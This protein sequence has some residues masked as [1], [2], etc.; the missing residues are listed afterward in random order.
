MIC[1]LKESWLVQIVSV[2]PS[3]SELY[4]DTRPA[5]EPTEVCDFLPLMCL[6]GFIMPFYFKILMTSES[7]E[8]ESPEQWPL[9]ELVC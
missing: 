8:L 9:S 4:S 7:S 3:V 2:G 6:I 1:S 5:E